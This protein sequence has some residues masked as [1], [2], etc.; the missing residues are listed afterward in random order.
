MK[1][2]LTLII[3]ILASLNTNAQSESEY[4]DTSK[5]LKKYQRTELRRVKQAFSKR[6]EFKNIETRNVKVDTFQ[7]TYK[8]NTIL[9]LCS[10]NFYC[11][12]LFG[13]GKLTGEMFY[14]RLRIN[15]YADS[16]VYINKIDGDTLKTKLWNNG[17]G[18]LAILN[19]K[20]L[21]ELDKRTERKFIIWA[22]TVKLF[23]GGHSVFFLSLKNNKADK[24]TD[25]ND[26]I[27]NASEFKLIFSHNEM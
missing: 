4:L 24:N 27:E 20:H 23:G 26:F 22:T 3:V 16:R 6:T 10:G 5:E 25:L 18:S 8:S 13:N 11:D 17:K 1:I 9:T 14:E 2:L 7:S 15:P 21:P 12:E 19:F